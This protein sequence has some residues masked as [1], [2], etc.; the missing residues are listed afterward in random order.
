[1]PLVEVLQG[2]GAGCRST[3]RIFSQPTSGGVVA[4]KATALAHEL[5]LISSQ[6]CECSQPEVFFSDE[7][8]TEITLL[9][10]VLAIGP[11]RL[12]TS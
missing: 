3:S 2:S 12:V 10:S 11:N 4:A 6:Q 9:V 1:V 7:L 8:A 5:R